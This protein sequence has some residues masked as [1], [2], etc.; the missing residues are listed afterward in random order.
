MPADQLSSVLNRRYGL[1]PRR[2]KEISEYL[3]MSIDETDVFCTL[4]A[5]EHG[6]SKAERSEAATKIGASAKA[7]NAHWLSLEQFRVVADWYHFA[8]LELGELAGV[9]LSAKMVAKRLDLEPHVASEAL[10][11]LKTLGLLATDEG[12]NLKATTEQTFAPAGVADRSK[13]MFLGGLAAKGLAA[14]EEQ[15]PS[16]R[17]YASDVL[18]FDR[19]NLPKLREILMKFRHDVAELGLKSNHKDGVYCMNVQFFE[20]TQAD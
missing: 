11:R 19:T 20:L 17:E 2:A 6:R 16:R 3:R 15:E 8:I 14:I 10:A 1:S 7:P 4:V 5:A 9:K 12:G 13:R 18:A